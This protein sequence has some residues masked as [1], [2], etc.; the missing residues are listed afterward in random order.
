MENQL[1][2]FDNEYREYMLATY[3]DP[4]LPNPHG[5]PGILLNY[6]PWEYFQVLNRTNWTSKSVLDTG[7]MHTYFCIWLARQAAHVKAIDSFYWGERSYIQ[8]YGMT[9]P[10][11]WIDFVTNSSNNIS[12]EKADLQNLP[13]K[14]EEFDIVTSISTIEHVHNDHKAIKEMARVVKPGGK[15]LITAEFHPDKGKH[16]SEND[17]S[18]YRIYDTLSFTSLLNESHLVWDQ[19]IMQE[20]P[21]TT[22]ANQTNVFV[23]L[24]KK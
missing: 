5:E 10:K 22:G 4:A 14:D 18:Y 24:V 23:S 1:I 11:E 8:Q 21:R 3:N 7:A 19:Y 16:Y 6:R 9:S 13:Y 2:K 17:G 20:D 12:A 15:L